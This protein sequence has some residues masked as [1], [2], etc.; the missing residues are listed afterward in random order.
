MKRLTTVLF[1]IAMCSLAYA[2]QGAEY[3]NTYFELWLKA[4]NFKDFEKQKS[5]I[6]F[7][8]NG[9]LL[10]GEIHEVNE[11]KPGKFYSVESRISVTFKKRQAT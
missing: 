11:L 4:H 3:V 9:A 1:L 10:D 7:P 2:G 6:S 8:K 5:G